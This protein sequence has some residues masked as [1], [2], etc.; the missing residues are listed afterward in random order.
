MKDMKSLCWKM[1]FLDLSKATG[2]VG[3]EE[4]GWCL[5]IP[6]VFELTPR[7]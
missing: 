1:E 6:L 7:I 5:Q 3:K 2:D 4:K